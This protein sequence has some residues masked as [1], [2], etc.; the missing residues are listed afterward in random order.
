MEIHSDACL[1]GWG[2]KV[3]DITTRGHWAHEELDHINC[4]ELKAI[5]LGLQSLCQQCTQT[6]IRLRSDNTTAI[7]CIYRC[8]STKF[9]LNTLTEQIFD[10][11]RWREITLSAKFVKG[12]DNAEADFESRVRNLDTEWMVAT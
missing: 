6:H 1:T 8:G 10:C 9:S 7:V 3:G 2:A 12:V 5:L 11:A 4:L